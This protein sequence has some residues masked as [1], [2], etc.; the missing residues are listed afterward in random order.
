MHPHSRLQDFG[1]GGGE[2]KV[3]CLVEGPSGPSPPDA[4]KH[5]KICKN[6]F[7]KIAKMYYFSKFFKIL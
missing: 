6:S 5:S 3:V 4:V 2:F 7:M 1:S